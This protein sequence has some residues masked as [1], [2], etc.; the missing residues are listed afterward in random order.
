[1]ILSVL[2]K[3]TSVTTSGKD[4]L[5]T[6]LLPK[7]DSLMTKPDESIAKKDSSKKKKNK[8]EIGVNGMVG[9]SAKSD[10]VSIFGMQ[11]SLDATANLNNGSGA[12]G[13]FAMV[14]PGKTGSGFAW[15]LGVYAKRKLSAKTGIAIGLNFSS[16]SSTQ[17]T[18]AYVDSPRI[19]SNSRYSS[20]VGSFYRSGAGSVYN[21]HYYYLQ[22]PFTFHWQINKGKK[23]PILFQ[24]G[25]VPGFFVTSNAL[26]YNSGSNVFYKDNKSF[27][28][29]QLSYQSGLSVQLFNRSKKPLTAG[30]LF[31]YH[32]SKQQK[33]NIYGGNHLTSFGI[34]LG[35]ILKK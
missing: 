10:G 12:V 30:F 27:N 8:W 11:K 25:L 24:N 2:V 32:L 1:M 26:V 20:S 13:Q 31:N 28:K 21:N 34:Q 35:W 5:N 33:V 9:I 4:K 14:R 3:T 22:L 7:Q 23:L 17:I 6:S 19:Y 16:Y 29:L 18:G 15:Q